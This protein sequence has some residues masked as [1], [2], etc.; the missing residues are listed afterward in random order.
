[1]YTG[2]GARGVLTDY[3]F[4]NIYL[5]LDMEFVALVGVGVSVESLRFLKDFLRFRTF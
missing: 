1:M 5:I 3:L 4:A 2:I